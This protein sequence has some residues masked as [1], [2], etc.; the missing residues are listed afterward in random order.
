MR[1]A[2]VKHFLSQSQQQPRTANVVL[3]LNLSSLSQ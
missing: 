1:S 2:T 3:G